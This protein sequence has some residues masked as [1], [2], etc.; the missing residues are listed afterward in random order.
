LLREGLLPARR[1]RT[2]SLSQDGD[3]WPFEQLV[4]DHGFDR[5][6]T[7]TTYRRNA[8]KRYLYPIILLALFVLVSACFLSEAHSIGWLATASAAGK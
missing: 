8:M 3:E 2:L 4:A 1:G 7:V 5:S 6:A